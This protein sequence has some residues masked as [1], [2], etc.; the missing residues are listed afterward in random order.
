MAQ[1]AIWV[2]K[3]G[4]NA[5]PQNDRVSALRVQH[6]KMAVVWQYDAASA[7]FAPLTSLLTVFVNGIDDTVATPWGQ[8]G[9]NTANVPS[10][11]IDVTS[12][13]K[14]GAFSIDAPCVLIS[15]GL[16]PEQT[17]R[18]L[19]LA[20]AT[21]GTLYTGTPQVSRFGGTV[22]D[23]SAQ[24]DDFWGGF[25]HQAFCNLLPPGNN[26]MCSAY[27]G[28]PQFFNSGMGQ[29]NSPNLST[30]GQ[31]RPE[32]RYGFAAPL[33]VEANLRNMGD[34]NPNRL[35]FTLGPNA[36]STAA[37]DPTAVL[38]VSKLP[39]VTAPTDNDLVVMDVIVSVEYARVKFNDA[40]DEFEGVEEIDKRK[41]GMAFG[42][43]SA[44]YI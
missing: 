2:S 41:I 12:A 35:Q 9:Y 6:H 23:L 8:A 28:L 22:T 39:A 43:Q 16:M 40:G 14:G 1:S 21:A 19:P 10:N 17:L 27:I 44:C 42:A 36:T 18:V 31:N 11:S 26:T 20:N 29:S 30:P 7:T 32:A 37:A 3:G 34:F 38:A 4:T 33:F 25:V 15:V 5:I 24:F 13:Y